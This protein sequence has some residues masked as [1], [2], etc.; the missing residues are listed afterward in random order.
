MGYILDAV[1]IK[2][3]Q[4]MQEANNTQTAQNRTLSGAV[5][6]DQFGSNKRVWTLKYSNISKT[7]FDTINAIYQSYLTNGTAKSWSVTETNYAV[8]ATTVHVS[9]DEREFNVG[10]DGYLSEFTLILT[11]A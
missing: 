7:D 5:S 6:R 4:Q 3:P 1:S 11:E 10:G 2:R 8:S 9:L